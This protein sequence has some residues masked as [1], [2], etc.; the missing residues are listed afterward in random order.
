MKQINILIEISNYLIENNCTLKYDDGWERFLIH[1]DIVKRDGIFETYDEYVV[2]DNEIA[3]YFVSNGLLP[4]KDDVFFII[5][6]IQS[7][8]R[9]KRLSLIL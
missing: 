7:Y 2:I 6:Y 4:K 8:I 9:D 1:Y 5:S 3:K